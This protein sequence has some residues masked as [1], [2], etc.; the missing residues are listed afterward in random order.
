MEN[1]LNT[2]AAKASVST[3]PRASKVNDVVNHIEGIH[4]LISRLCAN[5]LCYT[6]ATGVKVGVLA[7]FQR[8]PAAGSGSGESCEARPCCWL[9]LSCKWRSRQALGPGL[10]TASTCLSAC[11]HLPGPARLLQPP[12][13][14][15]SR[16]NPAQHIS[17]GG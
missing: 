15:P 13:S 2:S 14:Q 3:V 5:L 11:Q 4:V 10:P 12:C 6:R 17:P 16:A 9:P 1:T 8:L 7:H